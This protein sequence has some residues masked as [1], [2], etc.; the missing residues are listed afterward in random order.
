MKRGV[1]FFCIVGTST[2]DPC[3][4]TD[5]L[6]VHLPVVPDVRH[7]SLSEQYDLDDRWEMDGLRTVRTRNTVHGNR[8]GVD[9][10]SDTLR[11]FYR[12]QLRLHAKAS[13]VDITIPVTESMSDDATMY[14]NF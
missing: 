11:D 12:R 14:S 4:R 5:S 6:N 1:Y 8:P 13:V 7:M 10:R 2:R 3:A 9:F